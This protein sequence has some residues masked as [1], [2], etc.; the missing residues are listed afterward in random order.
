[1]HFSLTQYDTTKAAVAGL[2]RG[3]AADHAA[4]M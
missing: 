3:M 1:L 4:A 2:T